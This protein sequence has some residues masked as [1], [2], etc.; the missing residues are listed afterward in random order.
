MT[1]G[2]LHFPAGDEVH[3][4]S[5]NNTIHNTLREWT[6]ASRILGRHGSASL[7]RVERKNKMA[8]T[9]MYYSSN[10]DIS[11]GGEFYTFVSATT[12]QDWLDSVSLGCGHVVIATKL[13]II[14]STYKLQQ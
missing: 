11:P 13:I 12:A 6:T 7:C 10:A 14:H 8:A 4:L 1:L 5:L 3:H 9:Y 2:E